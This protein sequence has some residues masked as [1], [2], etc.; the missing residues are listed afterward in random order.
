MAV[1]CARLAKEVD[2]YA[3]TSSFRILYMRS[4][5]TRL[6]LSRSALLPK[7]PWVV[8]RTRLERVIQYVSTER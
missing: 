1:E 6:D 8:E 4:Q 2:G 7:L 3:T 5:H